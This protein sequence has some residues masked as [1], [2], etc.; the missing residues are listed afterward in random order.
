MSCPR[1]VSE[2]AK[3]IS[4][5]TLEA[6][7]NYFTELFAFL[8]PKSTPSVAFASA[9]ESQVLAIQDVGVVTEII[10]PGAIGRVEYRS[11]WWDAVCLKPMVLPVG[12]RIRVV[13]IVNITL[14]VEP[15]ALQFPESSIAPM[16]RS[17][18]RPILARKTA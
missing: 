1:G 14:V 15:I 13:E 11:S 4:L 2:T 12:T 10:Q 17:T 6:M 3:Q 9:I 18:K 16:L 7:M 8:F 5:K